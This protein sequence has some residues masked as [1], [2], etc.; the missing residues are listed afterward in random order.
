MAA[1]ASLIPELED[2]IER[3]SPE[4]R[5]RTLDQVTDLFLQ[6]A[7]QFSEE[8]VDLFDDVLA[9]LV[10]E[11]ETR[12]LAKLSA[13]LAPIANAPMRLVRRLAREDDIAVAG[14]VLLQSARLSEI[15]LVDIAQSKGQAHLLAISSRESLTP[16][17]TDVL[18]SRGDRDVAR[19]L[20]NNEKATFSEIGY[21]G[22][23]RRARDDGFLAERIGQRADVPPHLFR[24]LIVHATE[25]VQQKLL[26]STKPE[27]QQ[28][29][30]SILAKVSHEMAGNSQQRDFTTAKTAVRAL[31]EAG[32]LNESQLAGFA[33]AGLFEETVVALSTLCSIPID[34]VDRLLSGDRADPI[35][36]M[37]KAH[38][39]DWAT[40]RA[41]IFVRP[42]PQHVSA[43]N[44]QSAM[45]NFD[46]LAPSTAERVLRF[47]QARQSH[48]GKAQG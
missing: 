34:V 42:H 18:V 25:L 44:I 30:R 45:D 36:I 20:A 48:G 1:L 16:G 35:L 19:N 9:R 33:K 12:A 17:V 23:V 28:E 41:I 47:W 39:F 37:C 8:H 5:F 43:R 10:L 2:A 13:K 38:G 26:A 7:G 32:N 22:L 31:V 29:I 46:R 3:G 6:G 15:D 11:I 14:P 40:A 21:A 24:T 4:Q 27:R